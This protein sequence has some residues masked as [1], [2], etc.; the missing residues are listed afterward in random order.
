MNGA[1]AGSPAH[2]PAA[3]LDR[4]GVLNYDD[5]YIGTSDRIRWMPGTA[6][7]IRRLNDAGYYVFV[8]S[9]QSG[10]A[11]GLFSED[12]VRTLHDW[13]RGELAR[14]GAR[15]D[16]IRYCPDHPEAAIA[17]YRRD[18]DWR[19]PRPGMILDLLQ[20]WPVRMEASFLIGDK[21]IDMDAAAAAGIRGFLFAGGNLDAFVADCLSRLAE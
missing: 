5:N 10:V 14:D 6:A 21:A 17:R 8:V 12:D 9:N 11:R 13:M 3:F 2:R 4:D 16:D 15:I 19:K 20:H 18:S 1:S 7:A